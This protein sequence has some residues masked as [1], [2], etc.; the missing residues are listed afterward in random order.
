M[1]KNKQDTE[2]KEPIEEGY[3]PFKKGYRPTQENLDTT[4]PPRGGSGVSSEPSKNDSN[5]KTK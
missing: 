2:K 1:S 4:D 5:K 3:Q